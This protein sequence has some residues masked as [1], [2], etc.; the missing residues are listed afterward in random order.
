MAEAAAAAAEAG[1][2]ANQHDLRQFMDWI[3]FSAVHRT[4]I[5]TEAFQTLKDLETITE[6]D[7]TSLSDSFSMRLLSRL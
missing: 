4:R 1:L 7:I 2:P 6:K 5:C 3:G